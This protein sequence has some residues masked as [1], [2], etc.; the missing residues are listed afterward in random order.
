MMIREAKGRILR[1]FF[2]CTCLFLSAGLHAQEPL[3]N[4]DNKIAFFTADPILELTLSTDLE[5]LLA[6]RGDDPSYHDAVL[7]YT[8]GNGD[9]TGLK[10]EVRVRGNFRKRPGNC[11]FPPLRFK[12]DR[13]ETAGTYFEG[14]DAL[15]IVSHCQNDFPDFDQ[16]ILQEYLIYRMYGILTD[17]CLRVRLARIRYVD[18]GSLPDNNY[19]FAFFLENPEDMAARNGGRLIEL[20]TISQG[21]LDIDQLSLVALF[22]YMIIN[23]DYSVPIL[24]NLELVY[25]TD[26]PAPV[27]VP[28]DFDWSGMINIPYN[29]NYNKDDGYPQREYKGPCIKYRELKRVYN[30]IKDKRQ[31][32][33][34]LYVRFP[35]L[36][37]SIKTRIMN[38]LNIFF[39]TMED[40][41][42]V[43]EEIIKDCYQ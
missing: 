17:L 14:F 25:L 32:L 43:R 33:F 42:L 23:T 30:R 4:T 8:G 27:P 37:N 1:F 40:R 36:R 28:Y 10:V 39:L 41:N 12:F 20:E 15:K 9:S 11:D 38:D 22:N 6:D 35:Y 26:L 24:H 5:G 7:S 21:L 29:Y 19:R 13:D 16:Y 2:V 31:D 3:E 18:E 34:M